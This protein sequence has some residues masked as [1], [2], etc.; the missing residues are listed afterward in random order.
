MSGGIEYSI[1][2]RPCDVCGEALDSNG[3]G[4]I[5]VLELPYRAVEQLEEYY[6]DITEQLERG[7]GKLVYHTDCEHPIEELLP[8]EETMA[9]YSAEEAADNMV[10]CEA[11]GMTIIASRGQ[12]QRCGKVLDETEKAVAAPE[13]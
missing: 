12:C 9:D 10:E 5:T 11:C 6:P 3:K 13:N 2:D 1:P 4:G 8:K 7:D